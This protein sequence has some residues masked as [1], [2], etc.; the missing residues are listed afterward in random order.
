MRSRFDQQL[1]TLNQELTR[2]GAMCEEAIAIASKALTTGEVKLTDKVLSLDGEINHMERTIETLCLKLLLQQQPVAKDLRQ[3]SAALKMI[4]DMERIGTQAADIAEIIPFLGGR[5]GGECGQIR[6]MADA[7]SRMVTESIDAFVKQDILLAG[8]AMERDDVVDDL[9][10][11][12]KSS[13]MKLI[14][15][16]TTDGGYALDLLMIA[17]YFERIG[18]HAVN[19]AEWVAFSVT[20]E[21]KK[22]VDF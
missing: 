3:I 5:T 12:V 16:K 15:E 2:M 18:D 6:F 17:K 10:L 13:L 20:G 14:A 21:H 1:A 4:T 8:A 19:I 7:A 22:T 9:F 11:Q